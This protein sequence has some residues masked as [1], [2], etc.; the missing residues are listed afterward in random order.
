ANLYFYGQLDGP[1]PSSDFDAFRFCADKGDL[2]YLGLDAD[3][4]RDVTPINGVLALYDKYVSNL[5]Q[6]NDDGFLSSTAPGTGSLAATTPYSPAEGLVWRA[7]YTGTYYAGVSIDQASIGST[8][9]GDYLLSI[10]T[11]CQNGGQKAAD[12]TV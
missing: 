10:S 5:V 3:P 12:L 6:V 1:A 8:G 2:I 4:L 7:R 9:A 11:N